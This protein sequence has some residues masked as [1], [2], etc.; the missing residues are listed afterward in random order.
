M[1]PTRE[2]KPL[3]EKTAKVQELESKKK[4]GETEKEWRERIEAKLDLLLSK[5]Q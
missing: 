4:T 3:D 2:V 5:M 1:K